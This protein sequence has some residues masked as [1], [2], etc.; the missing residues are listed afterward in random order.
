M[1][2]SAR[3]NAFNIN[4]QSW[5]VPRFDLIIAMSR[6][7]KGCHYFAI[8]P[9][10]RVLYGC[11]QE[12]YVLHSLPLPDGMSYPFPVSFRMDI[13]Y[14]L[15]LDTVMRHKNFLFNTDI[16]YALFPHQD[17]NG[18]YFS[19]YLGP[20]AGWQV[21]AQNGQPIEYVNLYGP[22][23]TAGPHAGKFINIG[24]IRSMADNMKMNRQLLGPPTY[25]DSIESNPAVQEVFNSKASFGSRFIPFTTIDGRV[26][27]ITVYKSLFTMNKADKV[28]LEIRDSLEN[29]QLFNATFITHK[30]KSPIPEVTHD[31]EER[32]T[33]MALKV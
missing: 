8:D 26:Y 17:T 1:W 21:V 23:I 32:V 4:E 30:K 5:P 28:T 29:P 15:Y 16:P 14:D 3:I 6:C 31:Y 33:F 9:Q 22:D 11:P 2:Q 19:S 10:D 13:I 7:M 24:M 12:G 27:G 18:D 25:I 20:D